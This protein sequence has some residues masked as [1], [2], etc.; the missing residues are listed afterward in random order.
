MENTVNTNWKIDSMH[1]E[2][3]FKVKHMMI[4]TVTGSFAA[5]DAAIHSKEETFK[6]ADFSF[7]AK[8]DSINTKNEDRDAHLKSDDFF[9]A[10]EFPVL[11]FTSKSRSEEHTSELQSRGQIVC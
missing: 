9:N 8:V 1:S 10:E 3:Q 11:S 7:E 6:D 5:F 4:S 2:I